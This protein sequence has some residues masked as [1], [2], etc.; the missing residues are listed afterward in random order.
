VDVLLDVPQ[1]MLPGLLEELARQGFT[2]DTERV[3]RE[4]VREHLTALR[5]GSVRIDWLKPVL[6]LYLHTLSEASLVT[7][8]E[9][10]PVCVAKPEGLILT[11]RTDSDQNG[12]VPAARPSGYRDAT[13]R[14]PRRN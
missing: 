4:Y 11:K 7:W 6:P 9:G 3:I 12:C 13:D 5:Y 2:F 8:T 14:Q 10:H 1:L